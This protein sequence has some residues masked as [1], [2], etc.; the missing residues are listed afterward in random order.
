MGGP[1][2]INVMWFRR[3]ELSINICIFMEN[4]QVVDNS[5]FS[6]YWT[7]SLVNFHVKIYWIYYYFATSPIWL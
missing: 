3:L 2:D 4:V 5:T 7:I 6:V 1:I